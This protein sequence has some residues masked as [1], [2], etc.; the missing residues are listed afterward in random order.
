MLAS[1]CVSFS[2]PE[3]AALAFFGLTIISAISGKSIAK[4]LVSGLLGIF[5]SCV[6]M[7]PVYGTLRFTFNNLNLLSGID[8]LPAI[9]GFYS[10]PEILRGCTGK[11]N[12][13]PLGITMK[14][15]V[16]SIKKQMAHMVNII[17]SSIIGTIVGIIP[18]TGSGIAAYIAYDQAKRFSKDPDSF[19]TGN[20][21]GVIAAEA[22]NNG[23]CGGA[24]IPML[25][26]GI[27]GDSV[28]AVLMGGLMVHGYAPG[29]LYL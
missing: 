6:G 2:S 3:Y 10:I 26:L 4:G 5:I 1:V 12:P 7:D 13:Q 8:T 14:N 11:G 15:F 21:D 29:H 27:P 17:R 28:T 25:T 19:G 24:L 23:V 18:A 22:A 20:V 9:I 16:P